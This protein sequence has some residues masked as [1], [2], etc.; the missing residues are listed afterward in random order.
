LPYKAKKDLTPIFEEYS[1]VARYSY[2]SFLQGKS[3]KDIKKLKS[4]EMSNIHLINSWLIKCGIKDAE[5]LYNIVNEYNIPNDY[6][7]E[8]LLPIKVEGDK[9]RKGNRSFKLDIIKNNIIIFKPDKNNKIKLKL[10]K[11]GKKVKKQ[12]SELEE[13]NKVR[14]G[15]EGYP[16]SVKLDSKNIYISFKKIKYKK[17]KSNKLNKS[18]E[19]EYINFP[20]LDYV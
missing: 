7:L 14:K 12:L 1:K 6:Q 13:L 19:S 11:L 18:N 4:E 10:P 20:S 3:K 17:V 9:F 2:N 8:I 5:L 16:F 15:I